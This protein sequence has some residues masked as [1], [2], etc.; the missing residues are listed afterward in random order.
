MA[1]RP[2]IVVLPT[3]ALGTALG[4]AIPLGGKR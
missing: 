4:G 1:R 3:L 2:A